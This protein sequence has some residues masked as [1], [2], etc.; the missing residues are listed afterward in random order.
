[1][2]INIIEQRSGE[3]LI[4]YEMSSFIKENNDV[5][6]S[7]DD[8]EIMQLLG[9]GGFSEV[10]KVK[11]KK[12]FGIYAMKK[13]DLDEFYKKYPDKEYQKYYENEKLLLTKL[14]HPNIIKCY[15]IF[16]EN[17]KY[18]YFIMEFMNNGDLE[19][20]H[21]GIRELDLYIPEDKLWDIL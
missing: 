14:S 12:N 19:S 1:M 13:V 4:E 5:G 11:S 9:K 16:E 17:K 7:K 8:F 6:G 3:S 21:E 2:G 10:L 18:V 20:Y 15:N